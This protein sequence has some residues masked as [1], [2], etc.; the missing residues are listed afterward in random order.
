M[1]HILIIILHFSV[2]SAFD[3]VYTYSIC[4]LGRIYDY[5]LLRV[6]S[7]LRNKWCYVCSF[8]LIMVATRDWFIFLLIVLTWEVMKKMLTMQIK[9]ANVCSHYSVSSTKKIEGHCPSISSKEIAH[10]IENR[11]NSDR[12]PCCVIL[13]LPC[14]VKEN[15]NQHLC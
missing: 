12:H 1:H 2:I 5:T 8:K 10:V 11:M 7:Q 14:N 13:N 15:I 6:S 4:V 3:V 9:P